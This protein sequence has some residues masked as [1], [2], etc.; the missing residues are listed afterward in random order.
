VLRV[1]AD[2]SFCP[3][4][5]TVETEGTRARTVRGFKDAYAR[6]DGLQ[7]D[8]EYRLTVRTRVNGTEWS[9]TLTVRTL[10]ADAAP[11][12]DPILPMDVTAQTFFEGVQIT[13]PRVA[14][15]D[16][17]AVEYGSEPGVYTDC[18][19]DIVF[20]PYKGSGIFSRDKVALTLPAGR[21]YLRMC[22]LRD[23]SVLARSEELEVIV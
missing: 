18:V 13:F 9:R 19:T 11:A 2:R 10:P 6:L 4:T 1:N 23:G 8:T 21:S 14:G 22:A 3:F 20:N 17:Y 16:R 5:V 12:A 7:P 15:A